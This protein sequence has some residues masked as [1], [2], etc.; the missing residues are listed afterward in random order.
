MDLLPSNR[1]FK[2][3]DQTC[4]SMGSLSLKIPGPTGV[5]YLYV[6]VVEPDIPLLVGLD[7]MDKHRLQF[8]SI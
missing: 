7:L 2:F 4:G 6:D 3:G 5:L 8:L 1:L